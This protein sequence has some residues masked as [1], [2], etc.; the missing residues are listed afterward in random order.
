VEERG[1]LGL[2]DGIHQR[3][4][5]LGNGLLVLKSTYRGRE[6]GREGGFVKLR[7]GG[8]EGGRKGRVCQIKGRRE[9]GREEGIVCIKLLPSSRRKLAR[10]PT[11]RA[12]LC[13]YLGREGGREGGRKGRSIRK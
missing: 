11:S 2:R 8:R 3:D 4:D 10:K 5:R 1:V 13:G 12:C 6:G 7:E 9:G